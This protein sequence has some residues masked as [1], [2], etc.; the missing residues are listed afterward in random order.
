MLMTAPLL[1]PISAGCDSQPHVQ[2][3]GEFEWGTIGFSRFLPNSEAVARNRK[4]SSCV[5]SIHLEMLRLARLLHIGN[6]HDASWLPNL[7][8]LAALLSGIYL[9]SN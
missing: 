3:H 8:R 2:C 6:V 4:L 7:K 5:R 1:L 9:S